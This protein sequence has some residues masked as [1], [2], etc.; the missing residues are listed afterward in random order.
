[1]D[2]EKTLI[3]SCHVMYHPVP[4]SPS[5]ASLTHLRPVAL[6]PK[7]RPAMSVFAYHADLTWL[8]QPMHLFAPLD[9]DFIGVLDGAK[10][11]RG[12]EGFGEARWF[13]V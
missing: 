10:K 6:D 5:G 9:I 4:S 11:G 7:G 2:H 1:M 3:R 12:V 13:R 8:Q